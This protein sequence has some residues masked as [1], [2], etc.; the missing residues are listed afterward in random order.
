MKE[1]ERYSLEP[2]PPFR[3]PLAAHAATVSA[4]LFQVKTRGIEA[5]PVDKPVI[6]G[7]RQPATAEVFAAAVALFDDPDDVEM[8]LV[9]LPAEFS[10]QVR[11]MLPA[12][13]EAWAA[14]QRAK[15]A[16]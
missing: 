6:N 15:K 8:A 12:A 7:R 13:K 1:P 3:A 2:A 5:W 9:R 16:N 14:H 10:L 4:V 11:E